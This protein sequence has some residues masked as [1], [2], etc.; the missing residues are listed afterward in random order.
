MTTADVTPTA[1]AA[2][3]RV[4]L[5]TRTFLAMQGALGS[6]EDLYFGVLLRLRGA[7][8]GIDTLRAL[9][10]EHL[11]S[12]PAL[13]HRL[14]SVEGGEL[15]WERDPHFDI[16]SHIDV[17]DGSMARPEPA[18]VWLGGA[19]GQDRPLWRMWLLPGDGDTWGI[20]YI[21]HH[22]AQDG[23]ALIRTLELIFG[24]GEP[25]ADNL[26]EPGKPL[27]WR[28]LRALPN[29]L[30]TLRPAAPLTALPPARGDGRRVTYRAIPLDDVLSICA[31]S[32]ASIGQVHLAAL[33]GAIRRWSPADFSD[34]VRWPRRRGLP[35]CVPVDTRR[36]GEDTATAGSLIG[37]MRVELPCGDTDPRRRLR[38]VMTRV[39]RRRVEAYRAAAR[40][41]IEDVPPRIGAACLTRLGDRRNVALTASSFRAIGPLSVAGSPVEQVIAIP[42]LP[43]AHSCFSI[44]TRYQG[45]ATLSILTADGTADPED[46]AE[47]WVETLH[48]MRAAYHTQ[49]SAS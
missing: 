30:A 49:R 33:T 9:V 1:A 21:V 26:V 13:T 37:L 2:G 25:S 4:D 42:W 15:R 36:P 41:L 31:A 40:A 7:P 24:E 10:G 17:L 8:I 6:A 46:L 12:L 22:A 47:G 20:A 29:V 23:T 28:A 11:G 34:R 16:R 5:L 38:A 27:P 45:Q 39:S 43:P 32:A 35:V 3:L 48:E 19:P 44:L 18:G 14:V